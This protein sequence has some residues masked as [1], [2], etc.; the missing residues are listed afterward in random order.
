[1]DYIE[2]K[3]APVADE[4]Q[5]QILIA[6]LADKGF[7]SFIE[8]ENALIAYIPSE[9]FAEEHFKDLP[10]LL[11]SE[12]NIQWKKIEDQN[13]NAVWESNYSPVLIEGRCFI[14]APFHEPHNDVALEVVIEPKMS[15]G[16]AHHETTGL[17][18]SYLLEYDLNGKAVLDMGCGTGVL[19]IIANKRGA[20]SVIGIDNDSWAYNNAMENVTNNHVNEMQVILGDANDIPEKKFDLI[21]ANINRNILL[22]DLPAYSKALKKNGTL[23]MSGFYL[24]DLGVI[25]KAA[26]AGGLQIYS[27]KEKNNWVAAAYSN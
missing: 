7:E 17:M 10:G 9:L 8:E 3:F 19:G 27:H 24:N 20:A 15:F 18:I 12:I 25:N 22:G 14:R 21:I 26:A 5:K 4:E 13:W 11:M 2:T 1:M 6:L 16:T 23:I